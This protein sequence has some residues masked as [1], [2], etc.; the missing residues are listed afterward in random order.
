MAVD[1]QVNE[2]KTDNNMVDNHKDD[3]SD[4]QIR[5][6]FCDRTKGIFKYMGKFLCQ[7]CYKEL[8]ARIK[9]E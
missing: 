8:L 7:K 1:N 5:C 6:I 4:R 9:D 2:Y 3:G